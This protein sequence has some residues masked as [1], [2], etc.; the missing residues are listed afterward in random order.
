MG[1]C[2]GVSKFV[3][4]L[5]DL[6]IFVVGALVLAFSIYLLA[7]N[8]E[9]FVEKWWIWIAVFAGALLMIAA[10]IGC[11]GASLKTKWVLWVYGIIPALV[12]ILFIIAAIGSSVN[13]SYTDRLADKSASELNSLDTD[14]HTYEVYDGIREVYGTLWNDQNCD[15]SCT[16]NSL[17]FVECGEVTCDDGTV[18][19]WME[20]WIEEASS[21]ISGASFGRCLVLSIDADGIEGSES[22]ATGWCASNT[23]VISDANDWTLGF[24]IAFWVI[25]V[26]LVI[27]LIANCILISSRRKR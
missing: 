23:A 5:F 20:D 22:A 12:L 4:Y 10:V 8:Y 26:F 16:V 25:S 15:V 18:E 24:M 14:S 2:T 19:G 17:A 7:S 27:V 6:T 3:H 13:Y 1:F 21:G 11:I 9:G